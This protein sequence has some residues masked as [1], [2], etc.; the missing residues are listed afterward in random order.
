MVKAKNQVLIKGDYDN[1]ITFV[2]K[3]YKDEATVWKQT[4]QGSEQWEMI[5]IALA[6]KLY[7]DALDQGY[8]V[9]F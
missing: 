5:P 7:T 8:K 2:I 1:T 4:P 3:R 9:A 6:D